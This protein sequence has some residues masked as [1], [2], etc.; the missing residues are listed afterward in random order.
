MDLEVVYFWQNLVTWTKLD[1]QE[2]ENYEFVMHS[3][4]SKFIYR[5]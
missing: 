4:I 5:D 2:E 3:L 1:A